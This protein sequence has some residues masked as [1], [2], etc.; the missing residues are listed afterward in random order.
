MDGCDAPPG[1]DCLRQVLLLGTPALWWGGVLALLY[2]VL[3]W[4]G[5]RDWRF[6]VAVVGAASTWLPWFSTPD[7]P[8]FSFYSIITLPFLVLAITLALGKLLGTS[9]E[10]SPARTV[11][12]VIAGSYVVLVI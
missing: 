3:M 8:I 1:S 6:G 12:V 10:P 9:R 11:G 4:V 7:R 5:A 2:A